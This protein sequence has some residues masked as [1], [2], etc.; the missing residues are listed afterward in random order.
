MRSQEPGPFERIAWASCL[1]VGTAA[2]RSSSTK[3]REAPPGFTR[4]QATPSANP[5]VKSR[6]SG[7]T[8]PTE[9]RLAPSLRSA[10]LGELRGCGSAE[11]LALGPNDPHRRQFDH[12]VSDLA[13]RSAHVK[14]GSRNHDL[15]TSD[16]GRRPQVVG[17]RPRNFPDEC[18]SSCRRSREGSP[19]LL[20]R[21]TLYGLARS[22]CADN[23]PA[24]WGK[25]EA[26]VIP[27]RAIQKYPRLRDS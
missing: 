16:R 27:S 10:G 13:F 6:P 4:Q 11:T 5:W 23:T 12:S 15:S 22:S 20:P 1:S 2:S 9:P 21:A 3:A 24:R 8:G 26:C 19:A 14:L 25:S 7:R 17:R 18:P